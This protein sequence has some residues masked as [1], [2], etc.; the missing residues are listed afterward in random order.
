MNM[1]NIIN[2]INKPN[3]EPEDYIGPDGL[4][5]CGRCNTPKQ[6]PGFGCLGGKP[7]S[8]ICHCKQA[9]LDAEKKAEEARKA[10]ELRNLCLPVKAMHHHT[11]ADAGNAKHIEIAKRYVEKWEDVRA[12]NIGLMFWGNTGTGKTFTTHCI[13]N[14]LLDKQIP[15]KYVTAVDLIAKLMDREINREAF[16]KKLYDA[17]LLIIDDVG[18]ERDTAFSREQLCAVIDARSE[19]NKPLIVTTNYTKADMDKSDDPVMQRIFNR[20]RACCVPVAVIGESRRNQIGA[21]KLKQA[22]EILDL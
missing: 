5:Y 9:E 7:V 21:E 8:I 20:L 10:E 16:L 18:S 14:A 3:A 4:L 6:M 15:V 12:K 11:F 2:S 19:T 1:S 22:R 17:P 13:A